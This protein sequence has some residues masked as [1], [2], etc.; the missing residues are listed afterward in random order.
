[1]THLSKIPAIMISVLLASGGAAHGQSTDVI[2]SDDEANTAREPGA[3]EQA[4]SAQRSYAS[5]IYVANN[6]TDIA[7]CWRSKN[8]PCRSISYAALFAPEDSRILVGPGR[9]GDANLNGHLGDPGDEVPCTVGVP[10]MVCIGTGATAG[11][12]LTVQSTD[13]AGATVIDAEGLLGAP[14]LT[15]IVVALGDRAV[16]GDLSRG[17][18]VMGANLF[19][20]VARGKNVRMVGNQ[21]SRIAADNGFDITTPHSGQTYV[22]YNV[23]TGSFQG[24]GNGFSVNNNGTEGQISLEGNIAMNSAQGFLL[25]GKGHQMWLN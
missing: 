10:A 11:K 20:V 17:F 7:D 9:Y 8:S 4:Q 22:G 14:G 2:V 18:T 23:S 3:Q 25:L 12:K 21:T 6:G 13:G 1:M 15:D 19:G 5:N 24:Y 16:F